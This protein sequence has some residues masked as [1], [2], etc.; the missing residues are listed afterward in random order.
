MGDVQLIEAVKAGNLAT[1]ETLLGAGANIHQ[2]DEQG[3]T[4]LNW[5]AGKGDVALIQLLLQHGANVLHVGRDQRTPYMI[6]LAAARIEAAKL[7]RDAEDRA[8]GAQSRQPRK[9]C[10]A[11]YLKDLRQF[12]GWSESRINWQDSRDNNATDDREVPGFSDQDIVFLH[13]DLT[14]TQSM[15]HNENVLFQHITPAWEAFCTTVLQFQVP[16]D[17][18]LVGH[19]PT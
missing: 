14:V 6:A 17:L 16:D 3:W 15:W 11:F 10:K 8:G 18:D 9:Y 1:V 4:P 13:Q 12:P 7:L 2:Q 19:R 5:A